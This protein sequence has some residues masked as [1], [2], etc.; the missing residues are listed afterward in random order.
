V[1][2]TSPAQKTTAQALQIGIFPSDLSLAMGW[3]FRFELKKVDRV[4]EDMLGGI[5]AFM[6]EGLELDSSHL[7][8]I[9]AGLLES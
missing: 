6:R 8:A 2:K 5:D 1:H 4:V 9:R 3:I 7:G